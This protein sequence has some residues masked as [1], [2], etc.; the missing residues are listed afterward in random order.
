MS[1]LCSYEDFLYTLEVEHQEVDGRKRI[2]IFERGARLVAHEIDHLNGVLYTARMR[3]GVEPIPVS[4]YR[5][6]GQSWRY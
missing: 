4:E 3:P 1:Q 5:G 2:T 6:V